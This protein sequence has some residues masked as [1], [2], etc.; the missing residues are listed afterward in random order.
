MQMENKTILR[1]YLESDK[2]KLEEWALQIN[3]EQFMQ[4][5]TPKSEDPFLWCIIT[6]NDEDVGTI[7]IEYTLDPHVG[8][9]GIMLGNSKIYGQGI[10]KKAIELA[11]QKVRQ[12]TPLKSIILNVRENNLRAVSCYKNCKFEILERS[13]RKFKEEEYQ[14]LSMIRKLD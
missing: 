3:S 1:N 10:G 9:L 7:W 5:F 13:T 2:R 14:V 6:V 4:R 12:E 11:I 8:K